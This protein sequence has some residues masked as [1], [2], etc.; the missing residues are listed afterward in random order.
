MIAYFTMQCCSIDY[1]VCLLATVC[2]L[3]WVTTA[4]DVNRMPLLPVS[5]SF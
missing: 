5:L 3:C 2:L 4:K 1:E